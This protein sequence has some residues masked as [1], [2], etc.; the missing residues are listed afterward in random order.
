[1][2][3]Q[4]DHAERRNPRPGILPRSLTPNLIV[5]GVS[6]LPALGLAARFAFEGFGANPIEEITH[7]T[8]RWGLRLILLSLAVTPARRWLDVRGIAPL[9]RTLGLAGF[10]YACCHLATWSLLD[11]GLDG[12]AILEDLRERRFVMLG[13]GSFSLLLILAI[14]STRGG[15]KR[16]GARWRRLHRLVYAAAILAVVHHL[17]LT[18]ADYGPPI[19]HGAI[20]AAL[21]G[22]RLAWWTRQRA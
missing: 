3:P 10:S 20:L 18:K 4:A 5:I 22:A 11:L 15:S 1:M 7:T 6:C 21:L 12:A 17:W 2:N 16:L 14:T 8:G 13:M 19:V 9:R